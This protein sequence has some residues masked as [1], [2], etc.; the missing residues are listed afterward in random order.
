MTE[1]PTQEELEAARCWEADDHVPKQPELTAFRRG[2]RLHHARW[3]E[4]NG[5]PRGIQPFVPRAGQVARPVGS[6]LPLD[7][8]HETGAT[9]V[10]QAALAAAKARTAMIEPHQSIDHQRFWADLLSSVALAFNLFGDLSTDFS[11]ATKAVRRWWPDTPGVV[12]DV[13]FLHSPGRLDPAWLGN[14]V[15]LSVA[16]VLDL[17]DGTHGVLGIVTGYHDVNRRQPP[18]PTRLARYQEIAESSG[19]FAPG[20]LDAVNGTELVHIWLDH[21]L[22]LAMLQHP[23]GEWG[24]GR[25]VVVHP[26]E[27]TN[28]AEA[29][30]RYASLLD[31]DSTF[32]HSTLEELLA[33]D[34]LPRASRRALEKRYLPDR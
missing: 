9:F 23:D 2:L 21:L 7:Y 20:W 10:T 3:R 33:A 16:F 28:W 13:R 18:K 19:A 22:V 32:A 30:A 27:N 1:A 17:E 24:W 5:H 15:D 14:L 29:C 11:L 4:A 31:D 6:R 25:L 12:S 8:A 26:A 34:A